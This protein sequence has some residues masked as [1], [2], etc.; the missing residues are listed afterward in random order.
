MADR[1]ARVKAVK[2]GKTLTDVKSGST[3]L[4][5]SRRADRGGR[6]DFCQN[7]SRPGGLGTARH[8]S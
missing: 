3:S 2:V 4:Y 7:N 5:A 1:L 8:V 6:Q